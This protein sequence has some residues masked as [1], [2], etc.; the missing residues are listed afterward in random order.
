MFQSNMLISLLLTRKEHKAAPTREMNFLRVLVQTRHSR[1]MP[2]R[3]TW[4]QR[5][6]GVHF[7]SVFAQFRPRGE[8]REA[9]LTMRVRVVD[10]AGQSLGSG[11]VFGTSRTLRMIRAH[12]SCVGIGGGELAEVRA[13]CA[14]GMHDGHVARHL[15]DGVETDVASCA[16][17]VE[18]QVLVHGFVVLPT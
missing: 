16:L 6:D 4:T 3:N 15:V 8:N 10:V 7:C 9:L 18:V 2:P 13:V 17:G 12:M 11:V 5:A 1:K 14:D